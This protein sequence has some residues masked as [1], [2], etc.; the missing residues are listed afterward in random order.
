[1]NK[2]DVSQ[3]E[4]CGVERVLKLKLP[5]PIEPSTGIKS[6]ENYSGLQDCDISYR[7]PALT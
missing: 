2:L 5:G 3:P 4:V 6:G 1:M 7:L